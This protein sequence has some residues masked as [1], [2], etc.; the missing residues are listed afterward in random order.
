M[1]NILLHPKTF[2]MIVSLM[3]RPRDYTLTIMTAITDENFL[4]LYKD[5]YILIQEDALLIQSD[6][7][8]EYLA[9]NKYFLVRNQLPL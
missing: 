6:K 3:D 4:L 2:G 7:H 8:G 9:L 5:D 1:R